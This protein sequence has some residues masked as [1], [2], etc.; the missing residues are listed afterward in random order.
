VDKKMT[1]IE[2][3]NE[4]D[5]ELSKVKCDREGHMYIVKIL[6][7]YKELVLKKDENS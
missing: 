4:L 1:N 3:L 2:L 6:Q 7:A 5:K